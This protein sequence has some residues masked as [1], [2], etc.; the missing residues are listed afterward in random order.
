[1]FFIAQA[2]AGAD[3]QYDATYWDSEYAAVLKKYKAT[4]PGEAMLKRETYYKLPKKNYNWFSNF[5]R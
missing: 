5:R 4:N 3:A 1:M 2:L